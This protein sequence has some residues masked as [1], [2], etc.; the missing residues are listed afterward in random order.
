[1]QHI[2]DWDYYPLIY[3]MSPLPTS[4]PPLS[5]FKKKI[6]STEKG[7][8]KKN[9]DQNASLSFILSLF[10]YLKYI[11][12]TTVWRRP[13]LFKVGSIS[14]FM[15]TAIWVQ[16]VWFQ[17]SFPPLS[18]PFSKWHS[19]LQMPNICWISETQL[20]LL[21]GWKNAYIVR[22]YQIFLRERNEISIRNQHTWQENIG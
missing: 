1:M 8:L 22:I 7:Y 9:T 12:R 11:V 19:C 4:F 20:W 14:P 21:A 13:L 15:E 17:Q 16:S 3:A 10:L 2:Q 5:F 6:T 18:F